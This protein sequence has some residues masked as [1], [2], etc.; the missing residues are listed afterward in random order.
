MLL[1]ET[2]RLN[3]RIILSD[4]FSGGSSF[5]VA[6][7]CNYCHRTNQNCRLTMG[8]MSHL[9]YAYDDFDFYRVSFSLVASLTMMVLGPGHLVRAL[10]RFPLNIL[11]VMTVAQNPLVVS[12]D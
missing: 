7:I 11:L 3:V 4:P 12:V 10:F 8:L 2:L 6:C 9:S 5:C 1:S